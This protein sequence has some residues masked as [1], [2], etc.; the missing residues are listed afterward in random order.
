M[1]SEPSKEQ[2]NITFR[3]KRALRNLLQKGLT[4]R[5]DLDADTIRRKKRFQQKVYL[6]DTIYTRMQAKDTI[7][8]R[9]N[10]CKIVY[11]GDTI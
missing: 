3:E 2:I 9:S 8:K 6:E 4:C 7:T 10:C 1:K 11:L 5:Y